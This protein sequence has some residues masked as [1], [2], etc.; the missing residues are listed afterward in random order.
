MKLRSIGASLGLGSLLLT[1]CSADTNSLLGITDDKLDSFTCE[2][3]MSDLNYA[4]DALSDA[5]DYYDY[6]GLEV[7]FDMLGDSLDIYAVS[8]QGEP[9][10]W[11]KDLAD[12][13]DAIG[14]V[15]GEF[16][17]AFFWNYN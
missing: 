13:A 17:E 5:N 7:V 12:D 15:F 1:S 11:L 2:M 4:N 16:G 14:D 3:V 6:I 9:A 10:E 8:E